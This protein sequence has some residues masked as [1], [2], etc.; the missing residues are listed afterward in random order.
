M[1]FSEDDRSYPSGVCLKTAAKFKERLYLFIYKDVVLY[2]P[3]TGYFLS[4]F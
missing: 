2:K 1:S 3:W 4:I